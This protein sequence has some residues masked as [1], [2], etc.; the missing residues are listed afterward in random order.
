MS[1]LF[2]CLIFCSLFERG[3][4]LEIFCVGRGVFTERDE[5]ETDEGRGGEV[6]RIYE[7]TLLASYYVCLLYVCDCWTVNYYFLHVCKQFIR[8]DDGL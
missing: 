4:N 1:V 5:T 7:D 2:F 3:G 6:V 8:V